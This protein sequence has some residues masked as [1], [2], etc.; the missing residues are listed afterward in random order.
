MFYDGSRSTRM[1]YDGL[2]VRIGRGDRSIHYLDC[3]QLKGG[4]ISTT[5]IRYYSSEYDHH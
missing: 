5:S 3:D 1:V 2:R 4:D